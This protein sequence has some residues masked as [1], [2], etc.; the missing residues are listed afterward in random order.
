MV[1][2]TAG[3]RALNR[4]YIVGGD[5]LEDFEEWKE[6]YSKMTEDERRLEEMRIELAIVKMGPVPKWIIHPKYTQEELAAMWD[7]QYGDEY[8][9]KR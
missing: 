9:G 4:N 7:R 1:K 5:N 3:Y 8:L 2:D 6:R